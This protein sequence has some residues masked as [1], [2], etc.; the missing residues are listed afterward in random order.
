MNS[1]TPAALQEMPL[2]NVCLHICDFFI[3]SPI[4]AKLCYNLTGK[5]NTD[6]TKKKWTG[7]SWNRANETH[8]ISLPNSNTL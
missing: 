5:G 8:F 7:E 2:Y 1:T 4:S 6:W 3:A